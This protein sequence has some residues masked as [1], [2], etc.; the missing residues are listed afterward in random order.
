RSTVEPLANTDPNDGYIEH[1]LGRNALGL[2]NKNVKS[3]LF[4]TACDP[5]IDNHQYNTGHNRDLTGGDCPVDKMLLTKEPD[6]AYAGLPSNGMW[7]TWLETNR[8][9]WADASPLNQGWRVYV[10]VLGA[11]N[12]ADETASPGYI[13]GGLPQGGM[14]NQYGGDSMHDAAS[15]RITM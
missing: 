5:I 12:L 1:F 4:Q 7:F 15:P 13:A 2:P 9:R 11:G 3:R 14:L 10:G 6:V 8:D